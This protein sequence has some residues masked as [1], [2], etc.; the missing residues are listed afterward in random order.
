MLSVS[1]GVTSWHNP[2]VLPYSIST[3]SLYYKIICLT[4]TR[5]KYSE[6]NFEAMSLFKSIGK[7][8]AGVTGQE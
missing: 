6:N 2:S 8:I 1:D 7:F 3:R 5:Q 4:E